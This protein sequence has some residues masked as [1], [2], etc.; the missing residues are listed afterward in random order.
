MKNFVYRILKIKF[1][2]NLYVKDRFYFLHRIQVAIAGGM[3]ISIFGLAIL[4]FPQATFLIDIFS[5]IVILL[6]LDIVYRK[7]THRKGNDL[8]FFYRK[9]FYKIV[10]IISISLIIVII[11]GILLEVELFSKSITI[12]FFII[13]KYLLLILVVLIFNSMYMLRVAFKDSS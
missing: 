7:V 3:L 10:G 2:R 13:T 5:L 1:D 12:P 9:D 11:F 6:F 8:D 4:L